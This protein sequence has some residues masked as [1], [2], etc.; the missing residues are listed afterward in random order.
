MMRKTSI[1]NAFLS[2]MLLSTLMVVMI[3]YGLSFAVQ[4]RI[5]NQVLPAETIA[6]TQL[7]AMPNTTATEPL[8]VIVAAQPATVSVPATTV[9]DNVRLVKTSTM[10]T[11]Q[12]NFL[13]IFTALLLVQLAISYK[14]IH[15]TLIAPLH[16]SA[17]AINRLTEGQ[18]DLSPSEPSS[19]EIKQ[20]HHQLYLLS[21]ELL[22][23]K[24]YKTTAE[25]Q[26][27]SL[28]AGISHDLKT[29]LTNIKGYAETLL[30]DDQLNDEQNGFLGVILRSADVAN[31]LINDLSDMNRL[32]LMQYPLRIEPVNVS[33]LL[34]A[35][36][37]DAAYSLQGAN[38]QIYF[39]Q[40][41]EPLTLRGDVMLL[42][43]LFKNLIG[44]FIK[45]AGQGTCLSISWQNT[46]KGCLMVFSDNGIGVEPGALSK[47]T[48]MFYMSDQ[49]RTQRGNSGLGLYNCLQITTLLGADLDFESQLGEGLKVLIQFKV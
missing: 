1:Q 11:Y 43:R 17:E 14:F 3:A 37:H 25:F 18:Y 36:I 15:K 7:T 2:Y 34:E 21:E 29:P 5:V 6:V 8:S 4:E 45:H 16:A 10:S 42:Q 49:A 39:E 27:K 41:E 40:T 32:D 30:M 20:L 33:E 46:P 44:N 12:N 24:D 47:L 19:N 38:Q 9:V 35:C 28:I 22:R 23:A 31:N 48:E 13:L 26:R